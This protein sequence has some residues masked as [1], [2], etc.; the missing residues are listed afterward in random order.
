ML[1]SFTVLA[2][3][4]ATVVGQGCARRVPQP[5]VKTLGEPLWPTAEKAGGDLPTP[6]T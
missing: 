1:K 6:R 2:V 4:M 3:A 5:A